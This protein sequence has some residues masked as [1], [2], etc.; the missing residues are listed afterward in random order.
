M[1]CFDCGAEFEIVEKTP[2]KSFN[3]GDFFYCVF[4]GQECN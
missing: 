1:I 3:E 2:S 4:C